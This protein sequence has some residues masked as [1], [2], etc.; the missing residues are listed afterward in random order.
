[1]AE[2]FFED[3]LKEFR[4]MHGS[5]AVVEIVSASDKRIVARFSGHACHT[6]GVA[7][8]FDDFAMYLSRHVNKEW[9]VAG[10]EKK[11]NWFLVSFTPSRP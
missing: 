1:M 4:E 5:E 9:R 2:L 8:Y 7:D 10:F 11:N 3:A 6:C